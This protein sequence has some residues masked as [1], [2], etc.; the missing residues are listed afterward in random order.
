MADGRSFSGFANNIPRCDT[1]SVTNCSVADH[2][3][4]LAG[5]AVHPSRRWID[6][7]RRHHPSRRARGDRARRRRAVSRW[8]GGTPRCPVVRDRRH[9]PSAERGRHG[10][11]AGVRLGADVHRHARLDR[12]SRDDLF[13]VRPGR[14]HPGGDLRALRRKPRI[15]RPRHRHSTR[16]RL[17][18]PTTSRP[19]AASA[20]GRP[21]RSR[22]SMV[23]PS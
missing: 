1:L 18:P 22:S 8:C 19:V 11:G 10:V 15:H 4:S 17:R 7:R 16:R 12:D 13:A 14:R 23:R 9:R 5:A 21:R 3:Q 6:P 20:A 2:R